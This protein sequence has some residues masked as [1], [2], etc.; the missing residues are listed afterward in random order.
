MSATTMMI[1]LL[2]PGDEVIAC[3]DMYGGTNRYFRTIASPQMQLN[4]K[5]CPL[6]DLDEVASLVT[7]KTAVRHISF[8]L[9]LHMLSRVCA[10]SIL[11]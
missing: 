8:F 10:I 2:K 9:A 6:T 5:L 7:D 11:T 3:D 4:I 1:H